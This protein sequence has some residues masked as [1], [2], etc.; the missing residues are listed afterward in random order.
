MFKAALLL[1]ALIG[2]VT[3]SILY[4]QADLIAKYIVS[5]P[6]TASALRSLSLALLIFSVLAVFRGYFQGM[7]TMVPTAISQIVEQI[8]N[9]GF[10]LLFAYMFMKVTVQ[11]GAA[12]GTLGTGMGAIF[13][14]VFIVLIYF[15]AKPMFNKR[16][17]NDRVS[18]VKTEALFD[19]WQIILMTVAPMLI[20]STAYNLASLIDTV[21]F[22]RA[23]TF[24]GYSEAYAAAQ[25]GILTS[26]Y[27]ILIT[28]PVSIS[29]ALSAASIPSITASLAKKEFIIVKNKAK[30]AIRIVLL[31]AMPA[32]FGLGFLARPILD[33][34]FIFPNNDLDAVTLVMQIGGAVSVMT[35][36]LSAICVG[37]L[38]GLNKV[39]IPVKNALI[40]VGV[41]V[42]LIIV[43]LYVFDFGL[44][45]AIISGG[46]TF[47]FVV[48]IL[49]FNSLQKQIHLSLDY[50]TVFGIPF[51]S[52]LIMGV[53]ALL[54]HMMLMAFVNNNTTATLISIL[55]AMIVYVGAFI[56]FGGLSE[57]ILSSL[58]MGQRLLR[59][60]R[61]MKWV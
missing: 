51:L 5:S 13:G 61:K 32:A 2:L 40:A 49:N 3:S 59:I 52:S 39:K 55:I 8:F 6:G 31:I 21:L 16:M 35:F 22:Q 17:A 26:K 43:L 7:N 33:M 27:L 12:G 25:F 56:G 18:S 15:M 29:A 48:A 36:S 14:L 24:K 38:Q 10:S 34:L 50:K 53:T 54:S 1:G 28:L 58:P 11:K 46:V 60:A 44:I 19:Y 41:K 57:A 42:V 23:L 37:I 45:G 20:G 4:F 47:G 30:V 9:A